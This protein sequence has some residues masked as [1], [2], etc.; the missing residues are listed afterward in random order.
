[1]ASTTFANHQP[2]VSFETE[3]EQVQTE[4]VVAIAISPSGANWDGHPQLEILRDEGL[5]VLN[6]EG[7]EC[8]SDHEEDQS[9]LHLGHFWSFP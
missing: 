6:I 5:Q 2:S 8:R 4:T 3:L 1:M 7:C 9:K